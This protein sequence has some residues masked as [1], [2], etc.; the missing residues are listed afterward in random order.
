MLSNEQAILI[1]SKTKS[2]IIFAWFNMYVATPRV[3]F[4]VEYTALNVSK[5]VEFL[6]K[7]FGR[8]NVGTQYVNEWP[9]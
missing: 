6:V 7:C 2:L 8:T 1:H 5:K 9:K 4:L 3:V